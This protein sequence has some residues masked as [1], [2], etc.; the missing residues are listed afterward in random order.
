MVAGEMGR[1]W[2]WVEGWGGADRRPFLSG[3]FGWFF[4]LLKAMPLSSLPPH[5]HSLHRPRILSALTPSIALA[6]SPPSQTPRPR[7]LHRCSLPHRARCLPAHSL[8]PVLESSPSSVRPLVCKRPI[9][10]NIAAATAP[11]LAH[12]LVASTPPRSSPVRSSPASLPLL[13]RLLASLSGPH[14]CRLS[15]QGKT[16]CCCIV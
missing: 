10:P 4:Q 12:L 8:I 1:G 7:S 3:T 15:P 16:N 5:P 2:G 11:M 9:A 14:R 13:A 6:N